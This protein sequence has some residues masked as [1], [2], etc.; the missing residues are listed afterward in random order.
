MVTHSNS[1]NTY[2]SLVID[3][4]YFAVNVGKVLEVLQMQKI[5]RIPN[6][7]EDIKGV[8]NFRGEIIPVFDTRIRFALPERE[9]SEKYVIMVLEIAFNENKSIIGAIVDKVKDVFTI[10]ESEILPVPKMTASLREEFIFGI[11]KFKND[12]VML[13]DVDKMFSFQEK[14]LISEPDLV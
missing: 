14:Q 2:L 5:N 13:L 7:T 3:K 12:F 9:Q 6:V 1:I 11:Y 4:E 10:D 8:T